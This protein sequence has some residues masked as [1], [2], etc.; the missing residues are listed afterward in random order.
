MRTWRVGQQSTRTGFCRV[1]ADAPAFFFWWE[2]AAPPTNDAPMVTPVKGSAAVVFSSFKQ[3][4]AAPDEVLV[5]AP[6]K[7]SA[8]DVC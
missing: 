3:P 8:T 7:G 5:A 4:M 2:G 1:F 6:A